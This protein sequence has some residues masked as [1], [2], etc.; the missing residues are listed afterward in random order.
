VIPLGRAAAGIL[1]P[2]DGAKDYVA[3]G[4][5]VTVVNLKTLE[6]ADPIETGPEPDGLGWTSQD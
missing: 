2:P 6:S 5:G 1:M 4:D 3:F